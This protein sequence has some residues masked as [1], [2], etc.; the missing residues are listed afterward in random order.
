MKNF[1]S[2]NYGMTIDRKEDK[3]AITT[4]DGYHAT[5][6]I[7][8]YDE[9]GNIIMELMRIGQEILEERK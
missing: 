3:I 7:F 4:D 5:E 8:D 1:G 6:Y 9:L 2:V